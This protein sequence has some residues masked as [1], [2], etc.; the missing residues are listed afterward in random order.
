MDLG[1][2]E[3]EESFVWL[4]T[5]TPAEPDADKLLDDFHN[6]S[7]DVQ[8]S[9]GG[10]IC[11]IAYWMF[12]VDVFGAQHPNPKMYIFPHHL[13]WLEK[14]LRQDPPEEIGSKHVGIT[15]A[16]LAI[17]LAL[18]HRDLIV[19]PPAKGNGKGKGEEPII[20][21]MAYH[22]HLS[23]IL[24]FHPDIQVRN[25]AT[26]FAGKVFHAEKSD[27]KRFEILEDLFA[28][29]D[30]A[31]LKAC[32]VQWLKEEIIEAVK[33][34][35]KSLEL[36]AK[37]ESESGEKNATTTTSSPSSHFTSP[38]SLDRL[39]HYVFP[40]LRFLTEEDQEK[41]NNNP[42]AT[43]EYWA[44]HGIFLLQAANFAYFLFAGSGAYRDI[45]PP[46]MGAAVEH[47]F[48]EPLIG[49][50]GIIRQGWGWDDEKATFAFAIDRLCDIPFH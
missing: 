29:C 19:A 45:V 1:I 4:I 49:A 28:N 11:L 8:L 5:E 34:K 16:L 50:A 30:Y 13:N 6:A 44:I 24:V 23:L 42:Q 38:E 36:E 20:N 26:V 17:G 25:A 2:H 7:A 12:S 41:G 3:S 40:D 31:S 18:H 22:H 27:A 9:L 21:T 32:A 47:R 39:Q 14:F 15:D 35:T 43:L 46:G 33:S 37:S 48:A 10:L